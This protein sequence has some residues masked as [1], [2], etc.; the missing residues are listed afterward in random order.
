MEQVTAT[1]GTVTLVHFLYDL[2]ADG[3]AHQWRIACMP[4]MVEFHSTPYHPNYQRTDEARA[5]SCPACRRT[6]EYKRAVEALKA[7]GGTG[8]GK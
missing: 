3:T 4:N 5:V 1:G 2:S 7:M 6:A 8:G